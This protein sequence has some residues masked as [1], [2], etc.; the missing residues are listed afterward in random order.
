MTVR[1]VRGVSFAAAPPAV[2]ALPLPGQG[3]HSP[4]PRSSRAVLHCL[5]TSLCLAAVWMTYL[6]HGHIHTSG[7]RAGELDHRVVNSEP[8]RSLGR[9]VAVRSEQ[10]R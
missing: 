4:R 3:A 9:A 5:L 10:V 8:R 6:A 1:L 7:S 2:G